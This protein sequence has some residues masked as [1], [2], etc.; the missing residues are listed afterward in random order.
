MK[1]HI[2]SF[3]VILTLLLGG[4]TGQNDEN[5]KV[6]A[7]IN[8]YRMPL[9]EFQER[10]AAELRLRDD[11]KLTDEAKRQ[12][13]DEC[14]NTELLIQEAKRRELDR[15]KDFVAAINRYW[16]S[17]LLRDLLAAKSRE[18]A[19]RITVTEEETVKYYEELKSAGQDLAPL[20]EMEAEIKNLVKQE[21]EGR[22]MEEW[23]AGLRKEA[24]INIDYD[25]LGR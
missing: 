13:L 5:E 18:I 2:F 22:A 11:V 1:I 20:A 23:I 7:R 6:L 21:K 12:F 17:T 4:C 3:F 24:D 15:K 8:D 9:A 19:G 25:L 10:L 14:I 16:E